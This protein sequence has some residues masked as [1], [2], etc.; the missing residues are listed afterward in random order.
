MTAKCEF[1]TTLAL[2]VR[3]FCRIIINA[4]LSCLQCT[5]TKI[6]VGLGFFDRNVCVWNIQ[7]GLL[8]HF[9]IGTAGYTA[10]T[11]HSTCMTTKA[12]KLVIG[13]G[14]GM[15][16][17]WQCANS[18]W[19]SL[20][21]R[22]AGVS[23]T[24]SLDFDDD[25]VCHYFMFNLISL[26]IQLRRFRAL[27]IRSLCERHFTSGCCLSQRLLIHCRTG[28]NATDLGPHNRE[29]LETAGRT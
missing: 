10:L 3:Q 5:C 2:G 19:S 4:G 20:G 1:T 13:E 23:R 28:Y 24:T 6:I 26:C 7:S 11:S 18:S 29:V 14:D 17:V 9:Y 21:K 15:I 12:P 8:V 16:S 22:K 27:Q 25:H